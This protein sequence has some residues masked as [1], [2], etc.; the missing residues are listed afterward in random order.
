MLL[1]RTPL[2]VLLISLLFFVLFAACGDSGELETGV[3]E[4]DQART[5]AAEIA[6]QGMTLTAS[7]M[8]LAPTVTQGPPTPTVTLIYPT[9]NAPENPG[10]S[11]TPGNGET[12][13]GQTPAATQAIPLASTPF[14]TPTAGSSGETPCYRANLEYE[15]IPDGTRIARERNFVKVWRLKNTGTCTWTPAFDLFFVDGSLLNA[16]SVVQL[17]AIDVPPNG[18]V[19]AT[20]DM[21]SPLQTGTYTGYWMLRSPDG[22]VFGVSI[23]GT[24]WLWVEIVSFDPA[25]VP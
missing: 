11:P 24:A 21:Q 23:T 5:R 18:Y 10:G 2:I 1:K 12:G 17:T 3:S 14:S 8:S 25:A 20:V 15:T 16:S 22:V 4:A 6:N 13:S 7:A 9:T 19:D